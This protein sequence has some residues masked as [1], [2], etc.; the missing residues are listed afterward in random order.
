MN[1]HLTLSLNSH[2]ILRQGPLWIQLQISSHQSAEKAARSSP[3]SQESWSAEAIRENGS[4]HNPRG[5]HGGV[6]ELGLSDNA[7]RM[8]LKFISQRIKRLGRQHFCLCCVFNKRNNHT[9][10]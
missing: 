4:L 1:L 10:S 6:Y 8:S 9:L 3:V 7:P 2:M 5:G